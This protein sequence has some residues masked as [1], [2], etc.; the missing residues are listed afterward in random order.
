MRQRL[1]GPADSAASWRAA[2]VSLPVYPRTSSARAR[3][4]T[5]Q[6][7]VS[8]GADKPGAHAL[9]GAA[10]AIAAVIRGR[11]AEHALAASD[12]SPQRSA[13]RAIALGTMRWY[14]RLQPAVDALLSRPGQLARDVHA[15]L[16][17]AA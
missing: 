17:A 3:D 5:R 9:A 11:S 12:A 10:R 15:L 6:A 4:G 13:V 16:V 7:G 14:L 8:R 2:P 1:S